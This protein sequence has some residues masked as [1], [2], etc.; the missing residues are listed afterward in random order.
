[1]DRTSQF[2]KLFLAHEMEFRAF[3]GAL[4]RERAARDDVFRDMALALW[5]SYDG[6]DPARSF[7]A[8]ARGVATNRILQQRRRDARITFSPETIE[9]VRD[10]F[11][12]TEAG[13]G[14]RE[15]ALEECLK[16]LPERSAE[17]LVLRYGQGSPASA[18]AGQLHISADVV[19][20]TL[21]RLRAQLGECVRRQLISNQV[22][23]G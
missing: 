11:D 2:L 23:R 18:I 7:G 4:V 8:W 3:I 14:Q 10:A 21:S 15:E 13:P 9:A 5:E 19:N 12:R 1:M 17:I 6:Y 16:R 20:Q 22:L